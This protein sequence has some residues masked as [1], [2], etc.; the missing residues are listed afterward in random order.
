MSRIK[1]EGRE[2]KAKSPCGGPWTIVEFDACRR[3]AARLRIAA[4]ARLVELSAFGFELSAPPMAS[5]FHLG[6]GTPVT[7]RNAYLEWDR[8]V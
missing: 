8:Y 6:F 7:W 4:L 1:A 3:N 2:P 5:W